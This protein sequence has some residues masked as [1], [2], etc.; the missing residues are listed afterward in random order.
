V[1]RPDGLANRLTVRLARGRLHRL[2]SGSL[3]VVSYR[4]RRTG[5]AHV[6]PVQYAVDPADPSRLVVYPARSERKTW[7]R[8]FAEGWDADLVLRGS[9]VAAWGRVLVPTDPERSRAL[10]AYRARWPR[11]E[12]GPDEPLV[13]FVLR[14]PAD[15]A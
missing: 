3:L 2:V 9:P 11:V 4:G 12:V 13:G 10:A 1:P 8:N 15:Q 5:S 7:W 14:P 6:L